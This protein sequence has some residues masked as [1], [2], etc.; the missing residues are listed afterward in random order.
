MKKKEK[1]ILGIVAAVLLIALVVVVVLIGSGGNKKNKSGAEGDGRSS[2]NASGLPNFTEGYAY[3]F[4]WE[5]K[6]GAVVLKSSDA[7]P[8]GAFWKVAYTNDEKMNVNCSTEK[9]SEG[10][11]VYV[12]TATPVSSGDTYIQLELTDGK[13]ELFMAEFTFDITSDSENNI[14]AKIVNY[15]MR[16]SVRSDGEKILY[17]DPED[18]ENYYF[19][20]NKDGSIELY[21]STDGTACYV[22]YDD[23]K[24]TLSEPA[25][26][27]GACVYTITGIPGEE[28]E[29][30]DILFSFIYNE[31][32]CE[33]TAGLVVNTD[34]SLDVNYY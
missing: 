19:V 15:Y 21:I 1:I 13:S 29:Y 23:T 33:I 11:T 32:E 20:I 7:V 30:T 28:A 27:D 22:N 24:L 34:G 12:F 17:S 3:N 9:S 26:A 18:F 14:T 5:N 6:D 16:S 31:R 8:E 25:Y 4:S 2:E 10:A